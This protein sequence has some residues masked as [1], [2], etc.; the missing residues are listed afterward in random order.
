MKQGKSNQ[1]KKKKIINPRGE[2]LYVDKEGNR[3][4]KKND[5]KD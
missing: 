3:Q 1:I 5:G 2:K 4:K